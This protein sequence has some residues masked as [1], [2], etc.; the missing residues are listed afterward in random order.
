MTFHPSY[1][2]PAGTETA[3]VPSAAPVNGCVNLPR[4]FPL[5]TASNKDSVTF[6]VNVA[7]SATRTGPVISTTPQ[8]ISALQI[9]LVSP[10]TF[11][12]AEFSPPTMVMSDPWS[13]N[14]SAMLSVERFI[15]TVEA[16]SVVTVTAAPL[17]GTSN[18]SAVAS[19]LF[20]QDAVATHSDVSVASVRAYEPD[21]EM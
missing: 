21:G 11:I 8:S 3:I 18:F 13:V 9:T 2:S 16:I 7:P 4:A 12:F 1:V 10:C 5:M 19:A 15:V 20:A 14:A 6:K 17:G